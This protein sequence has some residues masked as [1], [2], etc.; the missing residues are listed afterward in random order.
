VPRVA[1]ASLE[2]QRGSHRERDRSRKQKR[3]ADRAIRKAGK[4]AGLSPDG[5]KPVSAHDLRHSAITRWI[6]DGVDLVR[7][8]AMAGHSKVSTTVDKYSHVIKR[9]AEAKR[10]A[11]TRAKM[12]SSG[13]G[14]VLG[15]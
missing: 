7:V 14:A 15:S 13:I 6:E 4:R 8:S 3:N 5:L 2:A 10:E 9:V 12:D 1:G 11:E